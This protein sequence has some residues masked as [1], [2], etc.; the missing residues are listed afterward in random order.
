MFPN[1]SGMLEAG[2]PEHNY[3]RATRLVRG[4]STDERRETQALIEM[5]YQQHLALQGLQELF[6]SEEFDFL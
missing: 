5:R 3:L 2:S 4:E 6:E 1:T